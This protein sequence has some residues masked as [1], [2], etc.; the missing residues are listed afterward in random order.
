MLRTAISI[1]ILLV[2]DS[3][4]S[5]GE[6]S[7]ASISNNA[8]ISEI[9]GGE[10]LDERISTVQLYKEGW[11]LS[12]P[13]IN[14]G[15]DEKLELH[16][17]LLSGEKESYYYTFTHCDKDWE[18]S[19]ISAFEY[20]D[21]FPENDI[22]DVQVSFNT[23]VPYY[24]YSL[25]FPN[26]DIK[27]LVSGNYILSVYTESPEDPVLTRRF[28]ISESSSGIE[29]DIHLPKMTV[30]DN[31]RQQVDFTVNISGKGIIDAS[32]NIYSTILQ[33]GRWD[34]G[35]SN[36]K[37]DLQTDREL[38]YNSLSDKNIF[39]G[40]NDYRPF[41]TRNIRYTGQGIRA[42]QY[43]APYYN[44]Y[45]EGSDSRGAKPYFSEPDFNGKYYVAVD[46]GERGNIEADYTWVHFS[47]AA[48]NI[49]MGSSVYIFGGLTDWSVSNRYLME[50]DPQNGKY[51]CSLLLKQGWYN[52]SY[53]LVNKLGVNDEPYFEGNHFETENDYT[54]I[55]YYRDPRER[56]DRV[57]SS[58]TVNSQKK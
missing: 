8:H 38:R 39:N 24:H 4:Q 3:P 32:K 11:N 25:S 33:N 54:V 22:E 34:S 48:N 41:D 10:I 26:D 37:P 56:Y 15:G 14:L 42:I 21:G 50:I 30:G 49:P 5:Y 23:T 46:D 51:V 9:V 31:S 28:I 18:P 53:I 20:I 57:I 47:L 13:V 45:L 2:L 58:V 17:D 12:Y 43:I 6:K 19:S 1:L 27:F 55:V 36:L 40:G 16:F 29:T 7:T 52:Y 44:M 35:H